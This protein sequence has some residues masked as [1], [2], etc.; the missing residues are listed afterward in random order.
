[1]GDNVNNDYVEMRAHVKVWNPLKSVAQGRKGS[2]TEVSL[3]RSY[4]YNQK[5]AAPNLNG[6]SSC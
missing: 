5:T 4:N 6:T 1:M 3:T 2:K